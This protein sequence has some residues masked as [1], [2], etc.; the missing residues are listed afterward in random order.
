MAP[1]LPR[2]AT[3]GAG[4]FILGWGRGSSALPVYQ[5]LI[6]ALVIFSLI[7]SLFF[8]FLVSWFVRTVPRFLGISICS[9]LART[10]LFGVN[11]FLIQT[12]WI[13]RM[14]ISKIGCMTFPIS[15]V[16]HLPREDIVTQA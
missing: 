2:A 11:F 9:V 6:R 1:Q 10:H 14:L 3:G 7:A 15:D 13:G 8:R 5:P 16:E 4:D 12:S